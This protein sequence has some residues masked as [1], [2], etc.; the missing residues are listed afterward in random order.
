M[1]LSI[2][3]SFIGEG[4]TDNRFL[5]NIA[6]R[7]IEQLLLE[8]NVQ[9]I[10]QWQTIVKRGQDSEEIILNAALQAKYCTTL[11][12]HADADGINPRDAYVHK[13]EP[14]L[15]KISEC[16]DSIVCKNISVVI[17]ITETEAWMLVDKELLK[18]E[19]N[20]SLS[21]NDLELTYLQKRIEK[22]AN[23]KEKIE[24]AIRLH[25]QHLPRKRRRSA[26]SLPEL[27]EPI[28]QKIELKKLEILNTYITFKSNI[29]VA[30]R[31]R[32]ILN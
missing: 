8:Q 14:G 13:L 11:I 23:P 9:A 7:M 29:I 4:T 18:D 21:N 27:Y 1:P 30:L 24:N 3:L 19:M 15:N 26:V 5:P 6:E 16:S 32:N 22:I 10:I 2:I 25:H 28:S 20:T 17:P 12:I 31:N